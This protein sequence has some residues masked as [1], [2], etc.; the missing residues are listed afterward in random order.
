MKVPGLKQLV[1]SV[2]NI[3][4][5]NLLHQDHEKSYASAKKT[6]LKMG[7]N[8]IQG[9]HRSRIPEEKERL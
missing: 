5:R 7:E 9:M 3:S 1:N 4:I 6:D 8:L 2:S